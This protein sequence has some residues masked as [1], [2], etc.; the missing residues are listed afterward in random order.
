MN[1]RRSILMNVIEL[2]NYKGLGDY[3]LISNA[4]VY[5]FDNAVRASKFPMSVDVSKVNSEVTKTVNSLA[6]A[7]PGTGHNNFLSGILVA[8]D[9][10]MT[11]KMAV[12]WQRYHF[13]QIVSSQ[14]TMHRITKMELTRSYIS[15][16]NP[17][18]VGIM[19]DLVGEYNDAIEKQDKEKADKLYLEILY[20]NPSGMLLTQGIVT[21]YLQLKTIYNQRKNHRLPEWR[22]FCDWIKTLPYSEW[23]TGSE[24]SL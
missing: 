20:S 5:N 18:I 22:L 16:V 19:L 21:N 12:E 9:I 6:G 14:S 7:Q 4:R 3:D 17:R 15:Y 2:D 23:I 11:N 24:D 10:T 8:F 13:Q 1:L